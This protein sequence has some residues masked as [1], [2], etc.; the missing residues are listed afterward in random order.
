MA[1]AGGVFPRRH[2]AA[3]GAGGLAHILH[4]GFS[5]S[6]YLFFPVWQSAFGLSLTQVGLLKTCY[7]VAMAGLQMPAALLAERLGERGLLAAG[8]VL[9]GVAFLATGTAGGFLTLALCLF[10]VGCGGSTQHPLASALIARTH[11]GPSRRAALGF[12]N[13][14]GDIGKLAFPAG[15]ALLLAALPW[16]SV[17]A[18]YAL[19]AVVVAFTVFVLLGRTPETRESAAPKGTLGLG[20]GSWGIRDRRG[21]QTLSA[22]HMIDDSSRTIFLTFLPFLLNAKGAEVHTIGLALTFVFA[23]GATGKFV[24]AMI[25]ERVG[26][27]RTVVITELATGAGV[28]LLLVLPLVPALVLLPALGVALNG[29][30][31]VLYGTVSEF[32]APERQARAF[33]LFY[34]LGSAAGAVGPA[35]YGLASDTLGLNA[36]FA[37]LS[38][39]IL[40]T[41]PLAHRLRRSLGQPRTLAMS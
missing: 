24:C 18:G 28:L 37:M 22:I 33:G 14:T 13:F 35:L 30:S 10:L 40:A 23:G 38:A 41:L 15:A 2:W 5:A 32:V 21:F 26:I 29:T 3:L 9:S 12:Y 16:R 7:S 11:E 6:I 34:T 4:D 27:I 1:Y 8:T 19:A 31:S 39:M 17:T 36:T 25:A 20:R